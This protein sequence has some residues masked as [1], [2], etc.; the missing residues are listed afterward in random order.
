MAEELQKPPST[1]EGP[2]TPDAEEVQPVAAPKMVPESEL[3]ALQAKKDR[4]VAAAKRELEAARAQMDALRASMETDVAELARATME[5]GQA[6][7]FIGQ[8]QSQRQMD[9]MR[10]KAYEADKLKSIVE[11][12][13]KHNIPLSEFAE[14]RN[15]PYA[16]V[17][18]A[19]AVVSAALEKQQKELEAMLKKREAEAQT[20]AEQA[21]RKERKE[22]GAD[23]ISTPPEPA[24][25]SP[26]LMAQYQ[27]KRQAILEASARSRG[28]GDHT[29]QMLALKR[30]YRDL[31]L[32]I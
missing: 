12:S 25:G 1:E 32:D 17:T 19:L 11:L 10:R 26:D 31:G 3:R 5:P 21:E 16:Q 8:R 28:R 27:Q 18:D 7:E 9:E 6:Q 13:E 2:V 24:K 15:N 14:V 20:A 29:A 23:K 30:E 4:E 22:S